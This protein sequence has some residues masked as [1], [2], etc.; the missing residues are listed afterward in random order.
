VADPAKRYTL[1][2]YPA[3]SHA[4][5]REDFEISIEVR[6][7][8]AVKV[9][10]SDGHAR[11]INNGAPDLP[12]RQQIIDGVTDGVVDGQVLRLDVIDVVA[13]PQSSAVALPRRTGTVGAR[14]LSAVCEGCCSG[15]LDARGARN[16]W[17][18]LASARGVG[19]N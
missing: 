2:H 8:S 10:V 19:D 4:I 16:A 12:D 14:S 11:Q 13:V 3:T 9:R 1:N 18:L 7:G 15:G 6:G 17:L 5:Y